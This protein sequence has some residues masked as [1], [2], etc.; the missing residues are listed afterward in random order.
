MMQMLM[1]YLYQ[2]IFLL[3]KKVTNTLSVTEINKI[4]AF[5]IILPEMSVKGYD[6]SETKWT[7]FFLFF[8]GYEAT[9]FYDKEL[10]KVGSNYTYVA[11]ILIGL[12]HKKDD[13]HYYPRVL[14]KECK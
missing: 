10:P 9:D 4:K 2:K 1:I 5:S 8:D 7:D 12:V 6:G 3:L 11:V 14:L 13:A